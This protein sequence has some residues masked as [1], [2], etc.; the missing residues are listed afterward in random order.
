MRLIQT[1]QD[2]I[3]NESINES[4]MT[5]VL[6][7]EYGK[8]E[9]SKRRL[10]LGHGKRGVTGQR[11]LRASVAWCMV[12]YPRCRTPVHAGLPYTRPCRTTVHLSMPY[13]R[14]CRTPVHAVHPSMPYTCP[15]SM[16]LLH[17]PWPYCMLHGPG[18]MALA[19]WSSWP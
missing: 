9:S 18:L 17:A 3:N 6:V 8:W 14:P 4:I 1:S 10:T 5:S 16:A 19:S 7:M 12:V 11:C 13:T 15:C 2:G